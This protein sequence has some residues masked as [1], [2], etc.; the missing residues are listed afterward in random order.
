MSESE[1]RIET[2]H[3]VTNDVQVIP[4]SRVRFIAP[5]GKCQFEVEFFGDDGIEVRG[6]DIYKAGAQLVGCA[7]SVEPKASNVV[8][9]RSMPY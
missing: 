3:P 5:D 2:G 8:I 4:G 9:I 6:V 7:V 1:R